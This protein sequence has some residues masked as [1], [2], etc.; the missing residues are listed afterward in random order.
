MGGTWNNDRPYYRCRFPKEYA[1][2][3]RID[4]P[5]SVYLPEQAVTAPLDRWLAGLFDAPHL[6]HTINTLARAAD[7]ETAPEDASIVEARRV[8]AE[9]ETQ[10]ARYRAACD[11]GADPEIVAGWIAE[12]KARRARA[13]QVLRGPKQRKR[14]TRE[15]I[16]ALVAALGDIW[17][18]LQEADPADKAEVYRQLCLGLTYQPENKLVEAKNEPAG[19]WSKKVSERGS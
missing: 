2:V 14:M 7:Q 11:A 9:T 18:T 13:E 6:E 10:L 12:T 19:I 16:A 8:L 15:E 4:H 5:G 3:N 1:L 17:A